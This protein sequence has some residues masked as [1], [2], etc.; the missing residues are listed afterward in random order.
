VAAGVGW[1]PGISYTWSE[2]DQLEALRIC[3]EAGHDVRATNN[4][5][6]TALHGAAFRGAVSAIRFLVEKGALLDAKEKDG[7]TPLNY[8]EGI[9]FGGQPPRREQQA[10]LLL[11]ELMKNV[12]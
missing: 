5:G 4:N 11:D 2:A 8:A 1:L 6:L 7:R 10:V 12:H 9:Y 3:L